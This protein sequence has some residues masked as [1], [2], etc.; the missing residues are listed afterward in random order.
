MPDE[1]ALSIA[2][3][4]F[5]YKLGFDPFAWNTRWSR[6]L[7]QK[8]SSITE[9]EK[10]DFLAL[11][12]RDHNYE[13]VLSGII[14]FGD[15]DL[16]KWLHTEGFPVCLGSGIRQLYAAINYEQY[17]IAEYYTKEFDCDINYSN[18][19]VMSLL[20]VF[21]VEKNKKAIIYITTHENYKKVTYEPLLRIFQDHHMILA[22][23]SDPKGCKE[24]TM[25]LKGIF[26]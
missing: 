8:A 6:I 15:L 17:T 19:H 4:E 25:F 26:G 21:V 20:E 10:E 22:V 9:E 18:R 7:K 1:D 23:K 3:V 24:F 12:A 16:L 14:H 11:R 2:I 5:S 13:M